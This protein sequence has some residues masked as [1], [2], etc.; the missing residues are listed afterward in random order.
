MKKI[1]HQD[2]AAGRWF[3]F[4]PMEQ[5]A[6]IGTEVGRAKRWQNKDEKLFEGAVA[7]ALELFDLTLGDPRWQGGRL[8]EI[9]Q[10][11]EIFSNAV[12]GGKEYKSSLEDLDRYFYPFAYAA[13]NKR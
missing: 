8:R 2:A 3:K 10:V 1:I 9:A 5:M 12:L 13:G 4:S 11:R 7:R 6:N